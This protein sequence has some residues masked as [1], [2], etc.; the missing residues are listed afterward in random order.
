MN[1]NY[2]R[3]IALISAV[4]FICA[5]FN[6]CSKQ[7]D[8]EMSRSSSASALGLD[9]SDM[10]TERDLETHYDASAAVKITLSDGASACASNAVTVSGDTVTIS[11]D[12]VYILS[13]TLTDGQ[14]IVSGDDTDK[15]QLVL[16]GVNINSKTSAAIYVREA[17]KVFITTS[18]S[19]TNSLS[20]SESFV[21]IDDNNID[22]AIFSK[23]DLTLNG[24]GSLNV[25]SPNGHGIVSKDDLVLTS[26][27]YAVSAAGHALSGKN[28]VRIANGSYEL[29]SGND[30]I[31]SE[32]ADNAESG[33]IYI[34]DG[35]LNIA[36]DG[37]GMDSSYILQTDGGEI[38]VVS[39]GGYENA[40]QKAE[41]RMFGHNMNRQEEVPSDEQDTSLS[42]KG[43]KAS[44][45]LLINSGAFDINS[46]DDALH[47]NG[48]LIV[49]DGV[50]SIKTGDDGLHADAN[51]S[52]SG[53][54]LDIIQS[55]EGI[56]G[57]TVSISGGNI[58][59][60]ADDDGL[61]AAGGNDMSGFDGGMIQDEF[62][63]SSDS[64]ITISGGTLNISAEGDG[65]DS[66][67]SLY[68]SGG[69]I[70][71]DGPES[72]GNG[73][74]D[75]AQSA[76]I[77]GGVFVAAGS[78]GMAQNFSESSTQGAILVNL[79]GSY[80]DGEIILENSNSE[81]IL[82]FTPQKSYN[83]VIISCPDIVKGE[84]YTVSAGGQSIEVEMQSLVYGS[85]SA[86]QDGRIADGGMKGGGMKEPGMQK[87]FS[88]RPE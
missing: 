78:S 76:E 44:V 51:T 47:S 20:N 83:C 37:D 30:G 67:G 63:E 8:R 75:Y 21:N 54:E 53:G 62:S 40:A 60:N 52:V 84:C 33:F 39:G 81:T 11:D 74:L 24:E 18:D 68:I 69:E 48:D 58:T 1:F 5:V 25:D 72:S 42:V 49:S 3:L 19:S 36:S 70:Y 77:T 2:K 35:R 87:E 16:N 34:A 23:S 79:S 57:L 31:H 4:I 14:I 45:L 86:I 61:N 12:G 43:L 59:V 50:I 64:H 27:E 32:N 80:A 17:N 13:G 56:E 71:V 88:D 7:A 82:S 10:F 15:I 38:T 55:Y 6:A 9:I 28:S 73:S 41:E 85:G 29:T 65:I 46:A 66:N 22:S 26:G